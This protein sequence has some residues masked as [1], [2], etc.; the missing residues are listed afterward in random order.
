MPGKTARV[1]QPEHVRQRQE[2]KLD[3]FSR[4]QL[5]VLNLARADGRQAA[6]LALL[7]RKAAP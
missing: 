2:L 3:I 1:N 6:R 4:I 7:L 5:L